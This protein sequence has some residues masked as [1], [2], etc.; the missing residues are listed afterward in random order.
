MGAPT[1][2]DIPQLMRL[3]K[4]SRPCNHGGWSH[5]VRSNGV[6]VCAQGPVS[7]RV[8]DG[9]VAHGFEFSERGGRGEHDRA[10]EASETEV[11]HGRV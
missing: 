10:G 9:I 2:P 11:D 6:R 3:W 4:F 1:P 5:P 7:G 8:L